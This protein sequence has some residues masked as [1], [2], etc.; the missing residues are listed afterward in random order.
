MPKNAIDE[1]L[2]KICK[3]NENRVRIVKTIRSQ[4]IRYKN[5]SNRYKDVINHLEAFIVLLLVRTD[6]PLAELYKAKHD[7][8][9]ALTKTQLGLSKLLKDISELVPAGP[10]KCFRSDAACCQLIKEILPAILTNSTD[11]FVALCIKNA[12]ALTIVADLNNEAS[13]PLEASR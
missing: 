10:E 2:R 13:L 6:L 3:S 11:N 5:D 9:F 4:L 1:Q 8:L 12:M 7:A